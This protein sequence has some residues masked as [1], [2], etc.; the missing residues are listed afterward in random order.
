MENGKDEKL[1]R[2]VV[3]METHIKSLE[4]LLEKFNW[5]EGEYPSLFLSTKKRVLTHL[6]DLEGDMVSL[7]NNYFG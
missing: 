5:K 3:L 2:S 4:T 1:R 6:L 7:K